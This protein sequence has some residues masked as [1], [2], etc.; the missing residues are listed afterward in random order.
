M[1]ILFK[2]LFVKAIFVLIKSL[3]TT[4]FDK[5]HYLYQYPVYYDVITMMIVIKSINVQIGVSS[6]SNRLVII[7]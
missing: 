5:G 1:K 4:R 7:Y 2:F 3:Y 6:I